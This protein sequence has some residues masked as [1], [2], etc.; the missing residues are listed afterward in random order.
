MTENIPIKNLTLLERNPRKITKEQMAKLCKSIEEDPEFLRGRPILVNCVDG[1]HIVYAGNQR[2]RAAKSLKMKEIPCLVEKDLSEDVMR[3]RIVLDNQHFGQW[4]FDILANEFEVD[5]LIN[6]G[7]EASDL[8]G[9]IH[10][11]EES[12]IDG[13]KGKEKAAKTCPHCNGIL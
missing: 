12:D 4:D 6:C 1:K 10:E 7:F 2:V 5:M 3:K 11:I 9:P 13:E 8:I